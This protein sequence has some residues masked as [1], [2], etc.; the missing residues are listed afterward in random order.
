M[1]KFVKIMEI[2]DWGEILMP[3]DNSNFFETKNDWSVIKDKL[4]GC[5][6]MPYF[7]TILKTAVMVRH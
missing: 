7:Q 2:K 4:L 1:F 3:K 5:Y 6:L